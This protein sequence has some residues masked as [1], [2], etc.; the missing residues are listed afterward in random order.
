MGAAY[1]IPMEISKYINHYGYVRRKVLELSVL[2]TRLF[3]SNDRWINRSDVSMF[4]FVL[5]LNNLNYSIF[6]DIFSG[7]WV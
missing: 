6:C 1:W 5:E 4:L 2:S 3:V 7:F